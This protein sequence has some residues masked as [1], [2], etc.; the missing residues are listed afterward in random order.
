[1]RRFSFT[2]LLRIR[3]ATKN[4]CGELLV[5]MHKVLITNDDGI[6][7]SGI[8]SLIEEL[9]KTGTSIGPN[10]VHSQRQREIRYPC[11][12]TWCRT[13]RQ[14]FSGSMEVKRHTFSGSI[15]HVVGTLDFI[16]LVWSFP[17]PSFGVLP[18]SCWALS[19]LFDLNLF[20]SPNLLFSLGNKWNTSGLCSARN[21][22]VAL[23]LASWP[24][25]VWH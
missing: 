2:D 21:G 11:C 25:I 7:A 1:M 20:Q 10:P 16:F 23:G 5:A 8:I 14:P 13:I 9:V 12:S 3:H 17:L 18:L 6:A 4:T 19:L 15:S 24:S 22:I